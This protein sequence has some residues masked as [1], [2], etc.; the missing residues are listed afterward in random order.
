MR[1][2]Q[3]LGI[4]RGKVVHRVQ[5]F[6]VG[7][8][9][10]A[11]VYVATCYLSG[12][13]S[14]CDIVFGPDS[15]T[16]ALVPRYGDGPIVLQHAING[17]LISTLPVAHGAAVYSAAFSP[18]GRTLATGGRAVPAGGQSYPSGAIR[19]WDVGSG[20]LLTTFPTHHSGPVH[21]V[22]FGPD[23]QTLASGGSHGDIVLWR[24]VDGQP[25]APVAE[26]EHRPR[27]LITKL[28][29]SPYGLTLASAGGDGTVR[30]WRF[31]NGERID[32]CLQGV[33]DG[34]IEREET[35]DVS[36]LAFS[37]DGRILA[38][39]GA[40][41]RPYQDEWRDRGEIRLWDVA[42]NRRF[43]QLVAG[44]E[45]GVSSLAF[46]PDGETLASGSAS[47]ELALWDIAAGCSVGQSLRGGYRAAVLGL[48]FSPDGQVLRSM[49][50]DGLLTREGIPTRVRQ[51]SR[52][53]EWLERF[54]CGE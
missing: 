26:F 53:R 37:P 16:V 5:G 20:R 52:C 45:S 51:L 30:L 39:G 36:S 12:A 49:G 42:N 6:V 9:F 50:A 4:W 40:V 33:A 35:F 17:D 31:V 3:G 48:T 19:L 1:D 27:Q 14:Y 10:F 11:A 7:M 44:G 23:G 15:R 41:A 43:D 21:S 18:D 24:T 54:R 38:W 32:R 46:S 25:V 2:G 34:C 47:G 29:F 28:A 22:A 8:L 13:P